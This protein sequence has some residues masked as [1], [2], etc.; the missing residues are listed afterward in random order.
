MVRAIEV[1]CGTARHDTGGIDGVVAAVVMRLDLLDPHGIGDARLLIEITQ[2]AGEIRVIDNAA[3]VALEVADI[4]GIETH[5]GRKQ[6][7]VGFGDPAAREIATLGKSA[8]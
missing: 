3:K 1:E 8:I 6:A 2:I 5:Q 7:P 4:D